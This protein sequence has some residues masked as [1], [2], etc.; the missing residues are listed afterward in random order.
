MATLKRIKVTAYS[1]I[2]WNCLETFYFP[3]QLPVF[4]EQSLGLFKNK[5]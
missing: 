1:V 2:E 5:A 3:K 4:E